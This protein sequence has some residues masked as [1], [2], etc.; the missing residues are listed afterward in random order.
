MGTIK[1]SPVNK[2]TPK[3]NTL[4]IN[5]NSHRIKA[6][7]NTIKYRDKDTR[8][9]V[10]YLPALEISGYGAT[11]KKALEM[12][13]FSMD[14]YFTFLV[15]SSV[16]EMEKELTKYG[17]Q[18]TKKYSNKEYSKAYIDEDGKL[19]NFNA[20]GDEVEIGVISY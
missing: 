4:H 16:K 17:W 10:I 3:E 1:I 7:L 20:V 6:V 14:E 9:I 5:K 8:Q 12:V 11:E 15:K 2:S 19:Q 13:K 18:H